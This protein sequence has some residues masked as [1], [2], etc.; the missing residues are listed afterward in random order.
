[1]S[2]PWLLLAV[3]S[4]LSHLFR[5]HFICVSN[6]FPFLYGLFSCHLFHNAFS[7]LAN[8]SEL[9]QNFI[10]IL[11]AAFCWEVWLL[12]YFSVSLAGPC[13]VFFSSHYPCVLSIANLHSMGMHYLSLGQMSFCTFLRERFPLE[14]FYPR[15]PQSSAIKQSM[16][17]RT[18]ATREESW[19]QY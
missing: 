13:S 11:Y 19:K 1:M 2:D 15:Q 18:N 16:C 9:S 8:S 7:D 12:V 6:L 10:S 5:V 3:V 14:V 4:P 17:W